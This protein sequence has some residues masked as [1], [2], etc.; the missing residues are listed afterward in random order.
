MTK[1]SLTH[2]NGGLFWLSGAKP[3]DLEL[4]DWKN[5]GAPWVPPF[6]GAEA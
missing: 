5:S 3:E 1:L 2:E 6:K 4:Q